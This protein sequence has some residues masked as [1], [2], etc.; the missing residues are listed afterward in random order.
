MLCSGLKF[1]E[2]YMQ[3]L[4]KIFVK[5]EISSHIFLE[6][7][8][9]PP[10]DPEMTPLPT[11]DYITLNQTLLDLLLT[12][13]GVRS[14][15]NK[16]PDLDAM[17]ELQIATSSLNPKYAAAFCFTEMKKS[18]SSNIV[19]SPPRRKSDRWNILPRVRSSG[20]KRQQVRNS[21]DDHAK[22]PTSDSDIPTSKHGILKGRKWRSNSSPK[23]FI[24]LNLVDNN[25]VSET[26]ISTHSGAT[27]P[28]PTTPTTPTAQW[29]HSTPRLLTPRTPRTPRE[30]EILESDTP[31]SSRGSISS[32]SS[33]ISMRSSSPPN[34]PC[35]AHT[36]R[37][38]RTRKPSISLV[39]RNRT[40]SPSR[41]DRSISPRCDRQRSPSVPGNDVF[42]RSRAIPGKDACA[43]T[44]TL[45][46]SQTSCSNLRSRSLST[47]V[48]SQLS[49]KKESTSQPLS[50]STHSMDTPPPVPSRPSS[51]AGTPRST[52][53]LSR[54]RSP[55]ASPH[56]DSSV[57]ASHSSTRSPN[58]DSSHSF[59]QPQSS[60]PILGASQSPTSSI[61]NKEVSRSSSAP[62]PDSIL[63]PRA[64]PSAIKRSPSIPST[65]MAHSPRVLQKR[66][67]SFTSTPHLRPH[68]P[69]TTTSASH[70]PN[71]PQSS[72]TSPSPT[73]P[74]PTA[75]LKESTSKK[76]YRSLPALPPPKTSSNTK[77]PES[78]VST[79]TSD[80]PSLN[81]STSH[82]PLT[83]NRQ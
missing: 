65:H 26:T 28:T 44:D 67:P 45:P 52:P 75:T 5:Y 3:P 62:G 71:L 80:N 13:T 60:T 72:F 2:P 23:F 57:L 29:T 20:E 73:Q 66:S 9:A 15:K 77:Q 19:V 68:P 42:I 8:I 56:A 49:K 54:S 69:S 38:S 63:S 82:N 48:H 36:P 37:T 51:S 61:P 39:S 53:L 43:D 6:E 12:P 50:L 24:D 21:A 34:T 79:A 83:P 10:P 22:S 30:P 18:S 1:V 70:L 31:S 14:V 64:D 33:V 7:I 59:I 32:T 41:S 76:V 25:T 74:P 40:P 55:S 4:N 11:E 46:S 17:N 27:T 58:A 81:E 35:S 47:S 16:Y 78:S